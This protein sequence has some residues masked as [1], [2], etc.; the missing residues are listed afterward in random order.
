[1]KFLVL[2]LTLTIT[3]SFAGKLDQTVAETSQLRQEVELISLEVENL[4][5]GQQAEMDVY[6]QRDQELT[7]QILK[8]KFRQEQFNTQIQLG[9]KKLES[10]SIK[11]INK[12]SVL[13][14]RDFWTK[15]EMSLD[16]A[17]PLY[18]SKLKDRVQKLKMD[19][20]QKKI[21]YEHALLQT[22]FVL[23]ND[24]NKS[25]E[26]DFSLSPLQVR[27]KLY[28]VEMVRLG[29]TKGYFRTAEGQYGQLHFNNQWELI[30]YDDASSK[31]MIETLLTQ[32]KQQQKTGLYQLPGINL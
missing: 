18:A 14:L 12:L 11:T 2:I 30:F 15:Y 1:M 20:E 21:S 3:P 17:H 8:E 27:E 23:E 5:K 32:F 4:K 16:R 29:R 6:I 10:Y 28:H 22:W 7:A 13:W 31:K 25:Q 9:K 24:L 26:A 19:F